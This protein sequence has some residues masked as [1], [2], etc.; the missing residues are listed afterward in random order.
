MSK[1]ILHDNSLNIRGTTVAIFD[2]GYYLKRMGY[3]IEIMYNAN[4]TATDNLVVDKFINEFGNVIHSY[5]D[6]NIM[7]DIINDISPDYFFAIKGGNYDGVVSNNKNVE[8]L[9]MAVGMSRDIHGDKYYYCSSW[10]SMMCGGDYV[11]H[12]IN[13]PNVDGDLRDKYNIPKDA[14]VITRTGGHGTFDIDFV[15]QAIINTIDI[16]NDVYYIMQNVDRFINHERVIFI[17]KMVSMIDKVKLI[18][19]SDYLLHARKQGESFGITIG[20][21]SVKNKGIISYANSIEKNHNL[22]LGDDALWY[23]TYD[24]ICGILKSI[25][26]KDYPNMYK[27]YLPSVV[28]DR[29]KNKYLV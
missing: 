25:D 8:N 5:S 28:M 12:M 26:K 4:D 19:T 20:E 24:D 16:R 10:L 15:R 21:F 11:P 3:D 2:Y 18:N 23:N 29:F 9:I 17:D 27:D 22:I 14:I 7:Q 13:I 6:Y 1:I